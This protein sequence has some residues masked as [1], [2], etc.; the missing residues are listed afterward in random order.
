L[1]CP[2]EQERLFP[3]TCD[4]SVALG[5]LIDEGDVPTQDAGEGGGSQTA[6]VGGGLAGQA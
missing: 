3:R 2:L 5:N 1:P 4:L 6:E